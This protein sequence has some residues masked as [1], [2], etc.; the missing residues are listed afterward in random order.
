MD[1]VKA[2]WEAETLKRALSSYSGF[3]ELTGLDKVQRYITSR[4]VHEIKDWGSF[5]LDSEGLL[6]QSDLDERQ[7]VRTLCYTYQKMACI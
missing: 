2:Q 1:P 7:T 3:C 4:R 5:E 6:L